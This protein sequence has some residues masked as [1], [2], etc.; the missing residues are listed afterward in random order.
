V[1]EKGIAPKDII[2][3]TFTNKAANEMKMRLVQLIG[4]AKTGAL[5]IGTFHSICCRLLRR[6]G[7]VIGL[8]SDFTI[9]DNT[10]RSLFFFL[11]MY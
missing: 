6:H 1:V 4:E 9:A 11:F 3:V 10:T 7:K 8:K 5:L 2:V